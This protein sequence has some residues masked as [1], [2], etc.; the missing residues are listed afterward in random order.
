MRTGVAQFVQ[1]IDGNRLGDS[2]KAVEVILNVV[3]GEG[4][5]EGKTI[6]ERMPL[7]PDC[8]TTLRKKAVGNLAICNEWEDVIRSTNLD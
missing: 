8:L 7:G 1:Q 6:P 5:A 4:V 2:K 3:K